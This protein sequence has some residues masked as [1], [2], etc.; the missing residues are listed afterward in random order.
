VDGLEIKGGLSNFMKKAI[1]TYI[2]AEEL[3]GK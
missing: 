3:A 2:K 1:D